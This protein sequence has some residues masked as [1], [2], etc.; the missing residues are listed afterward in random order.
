MKSK[1]TKMRRMAAVGWMMLAMVVGLVLTGCGN[2]RLLSKAKAAEKAGNINFFGF[3]TGMP[4]E[5]ADA[6]A[7]HYGLTGI[8]IGGIAKWQFE[9]AGAFIGIDDTSMFHENPETHEVYAM[10]FSLQDVQ[11]IT[12]GPN[13]FKELAQVVANQVGTLE[14]DED[15]CRRETLNGV[16]LSLSVAQNLNMCMLYDS[17]MAKAARDAKRRVEQQ[18]LERAQAEIAV[19]NAKLLAGEKRKPGETATITL[20]GGATMEMVWCPPGAFRRGTPGDFNQVTLTKG[21]W[22]G[23]YEVTQ[24]QWKSVMGN[25]PS[26]HKGDDL[27]VEN[28]R[29]I[30]C[31]EFCKKTGLQLPTEAQWEYACR[32][33]STG[34]YA[35]TG[36]LDDMGWYGR[37]SHGETHPV[38]TKQPN[39]WGLYDMHGNVW[40]WCA[41][42]YGDDPSG[43]VT[44]PTGAGSGD[45]RVL[46]SGGC[47]SHASYCRSTDRIGL[48]PGRV[49]DDNGFRPVA[50]QD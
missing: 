27:P 10:L 35:G 24:A 32:A 16:V 4:R 2:N 38:G 49:D 47:R 29:W 20:P 30:D 18:K 25:N 1:W 37:N 34:E 41:D 5:D 19:R 26:E 7:A 39:A 44:D 14:C 45:R 42:W 17:H 31:Q 48:N 12:K 11:R 6:L 36:N 9:L 46:R 23:K 3:Y 40:E 50:R 21:F 33:G 15:T 28:V 43:S 22:M 13:T 8:K